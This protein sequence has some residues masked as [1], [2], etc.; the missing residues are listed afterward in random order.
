MSIESEILSNHLI[1]CH[2]LLLPWILP[3]IRVFSILV[4]KIPCRKA[5]QLTP[6]FW[7][8]ESNGQRSLAGYS[9][10][11]H[12]GSDTTEWLSTQL[13]TH[14]HLGGEKPGRLLY[15]AQ[16]P[17]HPWWQRAIL[18]QTQRCRGWGTSPRPVLRRTHS[19][20]GQRRPSSAS[21]AVSPH[22]GVLHSTK[23]TLSFQYLVWKR[24]CRTSSEQFLYW[25][26]IEMLIFG[27]Y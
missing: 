18:A 26:Y 2:P 10:W 24:G 17:G 12:R 11:R 27:I 23:H 16:C 13:S 25:L 9:P 4:E 21:N 14:W 20:H 15:M 8:G 6:V 1:L 5:Q 7:P 3:S 22:R 19:G